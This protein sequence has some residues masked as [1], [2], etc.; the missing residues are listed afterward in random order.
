LIPE[1]FKC[2]PA[3]IHYLGLGGAR[4]S[5]DGKVPLLG[6]HCGEWACSPFRGR[7]V[8]KCDTVIWQEFDS[9]WPDRDYSSLGPFVFD[10]SDYE[11]AVDAI[12]DKWG[13]K[14]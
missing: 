12:A 8:A 5:R 1:Y 6:C 10:R 13:W 9:N 7:V 11:A 14:H 3:K 2:G 4:L